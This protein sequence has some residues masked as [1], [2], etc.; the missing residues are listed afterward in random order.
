MASGESLQERVERAL[1]NDSVID[2]VLLPTLLTS[3]S[4]EGRLDND[5]II[6]R[7][8][9]DECAILSRHG[10]AKGHLRAMCARLAVIFGESPSLLY[11]GN[12]RA[13]VVIGSSPMQAELDHR[14]T[15]DEVWFVV[16]LV[17]A[18]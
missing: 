8:G 2:D 5:R 3:R 11:G 15:T 16:T 7:A 12:A 13:T 4:I 18:S 1:T 6:L 14:N 10:S 9:S 17:D